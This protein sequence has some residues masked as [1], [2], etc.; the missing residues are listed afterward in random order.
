MRRDNEVAGKTLGRFF[1]RYP[2]VVVDN[3]DPDQKY[4]VKVR[5]ECIFPSGPLDPVVT[6]WALSANPMGFFFIPT[7][8]DEVWLEFQQGHLDF[9]KWSA[10]LIDPD[11]SGR[12][13]GTPIGVNQLANQ[14]AADNDDDVSGGY[15]FVHALQSILGHHRLLF[16]DAS[17]DLFVKL[18]SSMS[19]LEMLDASGGAGFGFGMD[20]GDSGNKVWFE[21]G[22]ANFQARDNHLKLDGDVELTDGESV[23]SMDSSG[24]DIMSN[25]DFLASDKMGGKFRASGGKVALGNGT[26][27]VLDTLQTLI[28]GLQSLI[29][30]LQTAAPTFVSTAVGPGVLAPTVVSQLASFL[31]SITNFFTAWTAMK[32]TL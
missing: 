12:Q 31:S 23:L 9:P 16:G 15:P 24:V 26:A 10:Q 19:L 2:A 11:G 21:D 1:G 7:R 4:R 13:I 17:S 20:S 29:T 5:C 14:N 32:G 8:G 25:A 3:D 6:D 28:A 18:K 30:V 22:Y 27:E